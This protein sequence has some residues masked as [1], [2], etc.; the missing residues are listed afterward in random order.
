MRYLPLKLNLNFINK[1][2]EQDDINQTNFSQLKELYF[3]GN[4][5]ILENLTT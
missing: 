1:E 5:L 2:S 3:S 4:P